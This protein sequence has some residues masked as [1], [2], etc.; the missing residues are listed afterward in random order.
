MKSIKQ[1]CLTCKHPL[2]EHYSDCC[3]HYHSDI[4]RRCRCQDGSDGT[5]INK[6]FSGKT[7]V[8]VLWAGDNFVIYE[9]NDG[10]VWRWM[11]NYKCNFSFEV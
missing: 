2:E 4:H 11:Y 7:V 10:A 3:L 8:N 9:A 5:Q 1:K 6:K